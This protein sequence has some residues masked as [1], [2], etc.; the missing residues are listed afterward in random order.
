M[1]Q[2]NVA[3]EFDWVTERAKCTPFKVFEVL[4]A[5]VEEDMKK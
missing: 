4:R 2:T 5:Q 3:E 1:N